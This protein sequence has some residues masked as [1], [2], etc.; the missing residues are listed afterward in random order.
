M[1]SFLLLITLR[2]TTSNKPVISQ[3]A[4]LDKPNHHQN[5][6]I[7]ERKTR[8]AEENKLLARPQA[9]TEPENVTSELLANR[10]FSSE[11]SCGG[12]NHKLGL[13]LASLESKLQ[14]GKAECILFI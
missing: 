6:V 11:V 1:P 9:Y 10:L 12:F 14:V 2:H 5:P 8:K 3:L 7:K 13:Q 4:A